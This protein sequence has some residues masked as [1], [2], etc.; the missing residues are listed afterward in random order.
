MVLSGMSIVL[1]RARS[2]HVKTKRGEITSCSV[3]R[4]SQAPLRSAK[5]EEAPSSFLVDTYELVD[6]TVDIHVH[7]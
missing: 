1:Q 6:F 3:S 7:V 2:I 4:S 5:P